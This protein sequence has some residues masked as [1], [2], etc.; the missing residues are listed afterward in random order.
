MARQLICD[1]E[2]PNKGREGKLDDI[3]HCMACN[4]GCFGGLIN[5][6]LRKVGCVHNPAAGHEIELGPETLQPAQQCKKVMVVGGGP[7]GMKAAE[8]AAR[9]GHE[10]TLYEKNHELGGQVRIAAKSPNRAEFEEVTH[11]LKIQIE[12]LGVT[13]KTGVEVTPNMVETEKPDAIVLATGALAVKPFH[14]Q[15]ADQDNVVTT[16]DI[17]EGTVPVGQNVLVFYRV[18]GAGRYRCR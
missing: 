7:A 6:D 11:W 14:I 1:P 4:Q 12:K 18:A 9:R 3:R 17:H 5:I 10:V 2:T 13:I 8:I 16:W 15:G